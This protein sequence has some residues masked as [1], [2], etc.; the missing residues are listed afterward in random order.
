MSS[1]MDFA[2]LFDM[3]V[4]VKMATMDATWLVLVKM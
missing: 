1:A 2:A 3:Y 4:E